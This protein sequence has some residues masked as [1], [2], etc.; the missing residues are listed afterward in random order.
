M[1]YTFQFLIKNIEDNKIKSFLTFPK[2]K[3]LKFIYS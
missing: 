2:Y 1:S 3:N